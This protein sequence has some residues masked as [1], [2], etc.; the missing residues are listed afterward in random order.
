MPSPRTLLIGFLVLVAVGVGGAALAGC[1]TIRINETDVFLP[2]PSITPS[3]FE[4]E[5]VT[6]TEYY[7]DSDSVRLNA[8]HL[9]RQNARG[10]VLFFGGNG[11][12]LVQ[13]RGYV[14]AL[15][16]LP[17]NVLMFDYRGY[18]K[19]SGEPA[20]QAFKKDALRMHAF[21]VD[22]LGIPPDELIVHG[23]SLG[24]FMA[25]HTASQRPVSAVVLENPAT[26]VEDW[27]D[28]LAP[29]FVRLFVNFDVAE[30]LQGESN[31]EAVRALD[32]PLLILAGEQDQVTR[33][34]M[35]RELFDASSAASKN[36]VVVD[37]MGHNHLY[38]DGTYRVA[39]EG[40]IDTALPSTTKTPLPAETASE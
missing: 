37:S 34:E 14:E 8:W 36:L 39:Y 5:G 31:V 12:Y 21:A 2:K 3:T 13:S 1:T 32:L 26:N 38:R 35:A 24:T 22:S 29:W 30:S 16:D 20:V 18:G 9:E 4:K 15:T 10:T 27:I 11:F 33:P 19:S 40:L 17:L 28:G 6:L 23:H 7:V 25:S